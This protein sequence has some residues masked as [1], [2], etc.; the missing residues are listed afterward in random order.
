MPETSDPTLAS[1]QPAYT[2]RSIDA[3]DINAIN[4][5]ILRA[6]ATWSMS[7]RLINRMAPLFFVGDADLLE[8]DIRVAEVVGIVGV[9]SVMP[10]LT[11][12]SSQTQRMAQIHGLFVDPLFARGGIGGALVVDAEDRARGRVDALF[13]KAQKDS[14]GFFTQVGYAS[15]TLSDYPHSFIKSLPHSNALTA[16][17][18]YGQ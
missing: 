3:E 5:V 13:C 9:C 10:M 8:M 11:I 18:P 14:S 16:G 17:S 12:G 2:I 15:S 4:D 7:A 1:M 6:V